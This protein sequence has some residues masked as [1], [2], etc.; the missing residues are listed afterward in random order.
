VFTAFILAFIPSRCFGAIVPSTHVR[1]WAPSQPDD[2]GGTEP[3]LQLLDAASST[4]WND[5]TCA[6]PRSFVGQLP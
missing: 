3:C 5:L 4:Q 2:A 1:D 6:F